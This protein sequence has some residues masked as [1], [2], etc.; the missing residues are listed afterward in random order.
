MKN[1][2][3]ICGASGAGKTRITSELIKK[4]NLKNLQSYTTR[5][6]RE[7]NEYGHM[8]VTDKEFDELKDIVAYT[9]YR[10][11]KYG[12]TTEQVNNSDL[13][14]IEPEGIRFFKEKYHGDKGIKIIAIDASVDLRILRMK[15]RGDSDEQIDQRVKVDTA[16]FKNLRDIADVIFENN[17]LNLTV[18]NIYE[19]ICE[20]ERGI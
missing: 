11:N 19:Y 14:V 7:L 6:K 20:Q 1:I 2:Y 17:D 12:A 4:Y 15:L 3:L 9:Y 18:K 5:P 13:Y 10:G 8:F 16:I